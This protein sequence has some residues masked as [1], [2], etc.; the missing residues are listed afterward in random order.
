MNIDGLNITNFGDTAIQH[1]GRWRKS[2]AQTPLV[3]APCYA[4][5]VPLKSTDAS[6]LQR[7]C[8]RVS[9]IPALRQQFHSLFLKKYLPDDVLSS[10][11]SRSLANSDFLLQLQAVSIDSP[12]LEISLAAFFTAVIGRRNSDMDLIYRSRSMY[13]SGLE[14]LREAVDD[15]R[16]RLS[17]ETLGACLILSLYELVNGAPEMQSAYQTHRNAA[18]TLLEQRGPD[19]SS[20]P[21]GHSL[22]LYVRAQ[23]VSHS[24]TATPP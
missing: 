15:H 21:L 2:Y 1:H 17:D 20:L 19:A 6:Q 22:L 3:H 13:V 9:I 5:E 4:T 12:A 18:M 23:T 8:Q 16:T 14:H 11:R 24:H 10:D 7:L